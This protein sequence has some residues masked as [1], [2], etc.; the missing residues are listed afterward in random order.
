MAFPPVST[1]K[2]D[3]RVNRKERLLALRSAIA[4]TASAELVRKRGH[5]FDED[6][7][8]PLVVSD[9]IEKFAKTS[10]AR[11]V[12]ATLGLWV[13]IERVVKSRKHR[14]GRTIHAK[15][16]LVVVGEYQ[17][18]DR[19]FKNFAGVDVVRA[20]DLSV[21]LLAPGTHPGRLTVWSESA[22]KTMSER[23]G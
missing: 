14:K 16:P 12:L 19:A 5:R 9:E 2:L 1:K 20:K 15:G 18:G 8:L 7:E 3:R 13:D 6:I 11:R 4:A 21:E 23:S 17:G 22:I 10:Q